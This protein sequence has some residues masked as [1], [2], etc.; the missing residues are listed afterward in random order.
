MLIYTVKQ[1]Y[2]KR[3]LFV[4]LRRDD[5][6]GAEHIPLPL[7]FETPYDRNRSKIKTSLPASPISFRTIQDYDR[8]IPDQERSI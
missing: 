7:Y 4:L 6:R 8:I 3:F 1:K 5:P 2:E